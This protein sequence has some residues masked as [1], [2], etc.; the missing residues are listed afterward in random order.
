MENDLLFVDTHKFDRVNNKKSVSW[1][2]AKEE[3]K[4]YFSRNA[5]KA[6]VLK[7]AN[8]LFLNQ[9]FTLFRDESFIST[10]LILISLKSYLLVHFVITFRVDNLLQQKLLLFPLFKPNLFTYEKKSFYGN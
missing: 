6:F 4:L 10:F 7:L 3:D 1:P 8:N 9:K 5:T 2:E